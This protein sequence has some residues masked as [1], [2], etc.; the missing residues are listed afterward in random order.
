[1]AVAT[2]SAGCDVGVA[3]A[4]SSGRL[5]SAFST[6][7]VGSSSGSGYGDGG[8]SVACGGTG[9]S[10]GVSCRTSIGFAGTG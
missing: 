6:V 8:S 10:P 4:G 5:I 3:V 9:V 2:G 1:M 7:G